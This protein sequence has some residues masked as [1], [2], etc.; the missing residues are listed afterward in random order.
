M[1]RGQA[2]TKETVLEVGAFT[3]GNLSASP[4]K[5]ERMA[6]AVRGSRNLAK[7]KN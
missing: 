6:R 2:E 3:D 7:S 4:R 5:T 1:H